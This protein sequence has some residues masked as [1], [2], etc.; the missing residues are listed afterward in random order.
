[1]GPLTMGMVINNKDSRTVSSFNGMWDK[2]VM[3]LAP[4]VITDSMHIGQARNIMWRNARKQQAASIIAA[5]NNLFSQGDGSGPNQVA[6]SI[7]LDIDESDDRDS[8]YES[9]VCTPMVAVS[10]CDIPNSC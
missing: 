7:Y 2:N 6:G 9:D 10:F 1:M 4:E 8:N 5:R 3:S